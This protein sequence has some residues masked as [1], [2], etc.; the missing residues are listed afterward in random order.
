MPDAH[1]SVTPSRAEAAAEA[2]RP[3]V[4]G[5]RR[6]VGAAQPCA[7]RSAPA[8]VISLHKHQLFHL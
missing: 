3:S 1:P 6:S 8:S 7:V 5:G 4:R 2:V